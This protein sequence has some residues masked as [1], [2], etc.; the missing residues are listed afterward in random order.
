MSRQMERMPRILVIRAIQ[1][2]NIRNRRKHKIVEH[3]CSKAGTAGTAGS[4]YRHHEIGRGT[5]GSNEAGGIVNRNGK[6][7]L[8]NSSAISKPK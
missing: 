1:Q 7:L 4:A 3:L 6:V 2:Q 8:V 5:E